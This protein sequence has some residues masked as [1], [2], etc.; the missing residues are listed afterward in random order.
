M[1]NVIG[2]RAFAQ[3]TALLLAGAGFAPWVRLV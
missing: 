3:Q 1:P 2:R